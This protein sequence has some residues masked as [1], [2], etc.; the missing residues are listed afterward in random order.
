MCR[1]QEK[2]TQ[3]DRYSALFFGAFSQT[4]AV[5]LYFHWQWFFNDRNNQ[6]FVCPPPMWSKRRKCSPLW[7]CKAPRVTCHQGE[8]RFGDRKS[9][10]IMMMPLRLMMV[11]MMMLMLLL[12]LIMMTMMMIPMLM[13]MVMTTM[14]TLIRM[15]LIIIVVMMTMTNNDTDQ[16]ELRWPGRQP[17]KKSLKWQHLEENAEKHTQ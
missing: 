5:F 15:W 11:M 3:L 2:K 8:P 16:W 13:M 9:G 12:L 10:V 17:N 6:N 4:C 1:I 7:C 14:L